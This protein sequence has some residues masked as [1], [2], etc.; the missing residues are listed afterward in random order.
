MSAM[1]SNTII[2]FSEKDQ[3]AQTPIVQQPVIRTLNE[4]P[5]K[6]SDWKNVGFEKPQNTAQTFM[7]AIRERDWETINNSLTV[8]EKEPNTDGLE[9]ARKIATGFR[10]L[11]IRQVDENT[12]DLKFVV[13]GW[14]TPPLSHRLKHT[15]AGWKFDVDSN[16]YEAKW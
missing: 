13:S 3:I 5:L 11:A 15:E 14:P 12:V 10:S 9:E 6:A 4:E 2:N 8:P 1:Y 16:T 7:W